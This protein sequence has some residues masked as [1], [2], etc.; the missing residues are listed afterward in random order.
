MKVIRC[1][2]VTTRHHLTAQDCNRISNE[3]L[4]IKIK[5]YASYGIILLLKDRVSFQTMT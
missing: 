1:H 3:S 4:I 2:H 5:K